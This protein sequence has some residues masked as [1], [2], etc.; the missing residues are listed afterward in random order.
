MDYV[1]KYENRTIWSTGQDM[2]YKWGS[3]TVILRARP[4]G[5]SCSNTTIIVALTFPETASLY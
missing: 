2:K 5:Q 4:A 3:T 1:N